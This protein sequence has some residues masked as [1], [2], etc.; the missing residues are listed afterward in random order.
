MRAALAVIGVIIILVLFGTMLTGIRTAQTDER[1]DPFNAVLT[2]PGVTTAPV[3][4]VTDIYDSSILNVTS[5]I[6][7]NNLDAPLPDGYV[8][9]T[10]TLTVRGLAANDT[11]NLI[12]TYQFGALTG[13]AAST[14]S[15]LGMIPI[16]VAIA[17]VVI[18]VGAGIFVFAHKGAG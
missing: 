18:L 14:G 7:D 3:V 11:R 4:L 1:D 17:A 6:S 12:V 16:F 15:F 8:P 13:D 10:N 2:A 5:I 9:A